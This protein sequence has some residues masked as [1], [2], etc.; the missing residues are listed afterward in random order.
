MQSIFNIISH[1]HPLL[2]HLPIGIFTLAF[3]LELFSRYKKDKSYQAAISFS[4]LIAAITAIL[5]LITGW[6]IPKEGEF[7][8]KL[9]DQ[10]FWSA[11]LLTIGLSTQY[12][13]SRLSTTS[14][15]STLYSRF[16]ALF[17]LLNLILLIVTGHFG[18]SLTHGSEFLF[19][20][21]A[22]EIELAET[23]EEIHLF[24]QVVR[25]IFNKKCT[26]CHNPEKLKGEL[27]L[28][29]LEG[30]QAGG[31]NGALFIAN[32]PGNSLMIE[33]IE[34]P[35]S[36]K[37]HMPPKGKVQLTNE[38]L[39]LLKWWIAEGAS[40]DGIVGEMKPSDEIRTLLTTY[41]SKGKNSPIAK[42]E[43]VDDSKLKAIR[44]QGI[45]LNPQDEEGI[46]FEASMAQDTAITPTK[47][48]AL[49]K[50][51]DHI[52]K[53]NLSFS[54]LNDEMAKEI[55]VFPHLEKLD[56]QQ[57]QISAKA[58]SFLTKLSY[59]ESLN[60]YGTALNDEALPYLAEMPALKRVYLWQS[61]ASSD[62]IEAFAEAH[63][64]IKIHHQIDMTLFG[65]AQLKPP[66][67]EGDEVLFKDSLQVEL[68][69]TFR[70]V[71][72]FYTLDGTE[73]DTTSTRYIA[74]FSIHQTTQIRAIAQK[75]GWQ[76]SDV[77]N[78]VY[79]Q[80]KYKVASVRL[81]SKP[82][83]KYKAKGAKS[84]IDFTKG[85]ERFS[86]GGW[87]GYEGKHM[88]ATLDLGQKQFVESVTVGALEDVGSYIFYPKAIEVSLSKDGRSFRPVAQKDIPTATEAHPSEMSNF[89]INFEET[90][91]RYV[92]VFVKSNLINP[93]Q[94]PAAGAK[95]W[96]FIDEILVN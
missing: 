85:G 49:K 18:G 20:N 69:K 70:G 86:E 68:N 90:E 52:V 64:F 9:V 45:L 31:K 47:L 11:I 37:K 7:D 87:L 34:L 89:L 51:R 93:P 24:E 81:S 88:T 32:E 61:K 27:L 55:R 28:T 96:I 35:H 78:Q 92:K 16:S 59:L 91:A 76:P 57:S 74:P 95:C 46:L 40:F 2:V 17:F 66:I 82:S 29:S 62:A 1:F 33:R 60:L 25:P 19:E 23:V 15:L 65:K 75:A 54:N 13:A 43:A 4:L 6:L 72:I 58:L 14:R 21:T 8:E 22:E 10:H 12:L 67:F 63:P 3:L 56:L 36:E 77:A 5:S 71:N 50:I 73:P 38:E 48:K 42:L 53:L 44:S 30:I 26:S 41:T 39:N 94:H 84:L 83:E 80:A 79:M